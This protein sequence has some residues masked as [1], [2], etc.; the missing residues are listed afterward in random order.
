MIDGTEKPKN[1]SKPLQNAERDIM[2][3][4]TT[5]AFFIV[6]LSFT[7]TSPKKQQTNALN[8]IS[9]FLFNYVDYAFRLTEY[10]AYII[11]FNLF[12]LTSHP[13]V[14]FLLFKPVTFVL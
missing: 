9:F 2:N 1:P 12:I 5:I 6:F 11:S 13:I 4:A 3:F 10:T 8:R 14:F 7:R